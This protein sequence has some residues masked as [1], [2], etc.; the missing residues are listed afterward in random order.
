MLVSEALDALPM[1]ADG[2]IYGILLLTFGRV[3]AEY[4]HSSRGRGPLTLREV[5]LL[6]VQAVHNPLD[7]HDLLLDFRDVSDGHDLGFH[8]LEFF[9]EALLEVGLEEFLF[10]DDPAILVEVVLYRLKDMG[11]L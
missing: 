11:D 9:D 4:L 6:D 8:F 10:P 1:L 3:D 7:R 5:S 2:L